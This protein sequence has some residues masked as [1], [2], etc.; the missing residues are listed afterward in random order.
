ML[1]IIV[2]LRW[3]ADLGDA[4]IPAPDFIAQIERIALFHALMLITWFVG[5][6]AAIVR[7]TRGPHDQLTGCWLVRR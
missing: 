5:L 6:A 3:G 7:P 2:F 4:V 1:F